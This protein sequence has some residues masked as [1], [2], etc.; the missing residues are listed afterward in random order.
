MHHA[1]A[2]SRVKVRVTYPNI[3][4]RGYTSFHARCL[5]L[6]RSTMVCVY[7]SGRGPFREYELVL[8]CVCTHT[9]CVYTH[10]VYTLCVHT[11]TG[12]VPYRYL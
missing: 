6:V 12:M 5:A 8:E 10:Y 4:I 9:L 1:C 3:R 2:R 7:T 11:L